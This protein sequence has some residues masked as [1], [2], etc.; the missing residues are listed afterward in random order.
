MELKYLSKLN[1]DIIEQYM[2]LT[3]EV[4]KKIHSIGFIKDLD[5]KATKKFLKSKI[6]KPKS[7]L[8]LLFD[9]GRIIATGYIGPSG[10]DT[11]QHYAQISKVMVDPKVQGK[12]YGKKIMAELERKAKEI[13]Y[14]HILIDTWNVDYIVRF[15]KK[16]GYRQVGII[17]DFVKYKGEFHDSYLFAKK[18]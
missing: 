16:C 9:K 11:T 12:G 6:S 18:L 7:A 2:N 14:S 10:H 17:P 15:Y 1:E 3:N 13:G 5:F 8:L 4:I